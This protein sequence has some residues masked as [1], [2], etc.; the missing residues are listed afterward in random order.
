[1]VARLVVAAP[2]S[3]HGKTTVAAGLMAALRAR[4]LVVS[5]HK[6]GP[7]FIDPSYHALA[8]GR[9]PRNL[10]PFLQSEDL[11]VPL[12][13]HGAGGAGIAVI[14]GVMGLFDGALGTEGFASTA[15]VARLLEAPVVLVVDASAASRSVAATVLGFA[16]YDPRVTLAGVILNKLGSQRH[17]DEIR[18]ALVP[19]GIPVLGALRRSEDIHAPSRHL[20]LVPAEER[21]AE[22]RQLLPRLAEWI[23]DGV[24]LEAVV[25]VARTA[26]RLSGTAW[27]PDGTWTGPRRVVAAAAGEA[28]TFRYTETVELL[29]SHGIDVVDLDPLH[30]KGL[31][32]DCA[33]L[34]FGGGF[35]EVHA[36]ALSDNASLREGVA[37]AIRGGMPVVA[38]CAGLLYLC[39]ELD[40]LPMV[41]AV[42]ALARM[43]KRGALGYRRAT[44]PR[45]TVLARAG[46]RVTGHEF[47]R[48]EVL[49][50]Q[51]ETPAWE[52]D[53]TG[54]GFA[55][56]TLHASYLHVHWAGHPGLAR[57][58]AAA[59]HARGR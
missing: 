47:H 55:S 35:P 41:G 38:E 34:Y 11:L 3:G 15:H 40:G 16:R 39:R 50:R 30:D 42:D 13:L 27:R 1:M 24:D 51:G 17:E 31:P 46:A 52:W 58:F 48:T 36:G 26:P 14:E 10:D 22:S 23:A 18:A 20:G 21:G 54:E 25:R 49:P 32:E 19:T 4:G 12:L 28:F 29:D 57:S 6:V 37:T 53:G 44:A 43:T 45:D 7:D 56:A 59:V 5:G 8:T 33:G 2:G 9:P